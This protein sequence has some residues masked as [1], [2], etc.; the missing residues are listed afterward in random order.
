MNVLLSV[1]QRLR[2][3]TTSETKADVRK[4]DK[5]D[6]KAPKISETVSL[7]PAIFIKASSNVPFKFWLFRFTV[8]LLPSNEVWCFCFYFLC[9]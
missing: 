9:F 1:T 8:Y 3:G 2:K 6:K 5:K 4:G 7:Y